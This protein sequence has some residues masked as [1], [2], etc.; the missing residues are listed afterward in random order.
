MLGAEA[1]GGDGKTGRPI[2]IQTFL[3]HFYVPRAWATPWNK[4]NAELLLWQGR[5][6]REQ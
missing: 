2:F 1:G 4:V 3:E 5:E 6:S